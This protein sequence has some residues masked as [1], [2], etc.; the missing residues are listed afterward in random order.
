MQQMETH[1]VEPL[2]IQ[3]DPHLKLAAIANAARQRPQ[4]AAGG[5]LL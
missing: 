1:I 4:A 2:S 5:Q 3:Q